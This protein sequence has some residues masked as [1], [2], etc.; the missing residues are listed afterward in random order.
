MEFWG[1]LVCP[2]CKQ[3]G[4][5]LSTSALP[6]ADLL[7][8]HGYA[9]CDNCKRLYPIAEHILDMAAHEP[10]PAL[11]LAGW[12]NHFPPTPQLYER[13]WRR[14]ALTI[15]TGEAFSVEREWNRMNEW[16]QLQAGECAV[17]LGTSTGLYARGVVPK[18]ATVFA[19]DM[20]WEMLREA[21]RYIAREKRSGI[22]LM[23]AAAEKL[24]FRNESIDAVMVGGSL[25]EM[26]AIPAALTEANRVTRRG[27]RMFVMS[28]SRATKNPGKVLQGLAGL[29]GIKFPGAD[30]FNAMAQGAGWNVA[31]QEQKGIVLF[32]LL[33]K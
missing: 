31:K 4:L 29:S 26:K 15:M 23:R 11:T 17:D 27:G 18:E 21:R 12:S 19:V 25:N 9:V 8:E 32:S 14:R 30:E 22:V 28:L 16:T 2:V 1:E 3:S 10:R 20:A 33:S 6:G 7:P 5:R 13:I 24:P